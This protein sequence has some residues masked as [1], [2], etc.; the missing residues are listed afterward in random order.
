SPL[1]RWMN[2]ARARAFAS[3]RAARIARYDDR[4]VP[5]ASSRNAPAI[6]RATALLRPYQRRD[7]RQ[8]RSVQLTGRARIGS[9]ARKRRRSSANARALAYLRPGSFSKHLSVIVSASRG[10]IGTSRDGGTGSAVLTYS[11]VSSAE[12]PRNG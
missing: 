7:Q 6:A 1:R 5:T 4:P 10:T 2:A 12:A 9:S 3:S 8:A 11:I